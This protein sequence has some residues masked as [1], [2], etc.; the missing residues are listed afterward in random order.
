MLKSVKDRLQTPTFANVDK[1]SA[2]CS[3]EGGVR[4][5]CA[6]HMAPPNGSLA[7][8]RAYQL[9]PGRES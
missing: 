4:V 3:H 8:L 6:P 2:C 5:L 9:A 1:H 7:G